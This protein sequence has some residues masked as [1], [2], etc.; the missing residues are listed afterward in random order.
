[1]LCILQARLQ[2]W[3]VFGILLLIET[4]FVLFLFL[5]SP[6]PLQPLQGASCFKAVLLRKSPQCW[7]LLLPHKMVQKHKL[8]LWVSRN[9]TK[10]GLFPAAC[11][12]SPTSGLPVI[13][14][15]RSLSAESQRY[16]L[17]YI[18]DI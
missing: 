5:S 15:V 8:S 2:G 12:P 13:T 6:H 11:S 3:I 14:N 4:Y 1:M 17:F 16:N 9:V 7:S 18:F 10:N